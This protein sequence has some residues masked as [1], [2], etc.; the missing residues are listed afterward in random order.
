MAAKTFLGTG[1]GSIQTGIF[2][3]DRLDRIVRDLPRKLDHQDR[4]IG[5]IRLCL[6]QQVM[7]VRFMALA[8]E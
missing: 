3:R 2:L 8:A 6:E 7:P 4:V 1:P 5:T